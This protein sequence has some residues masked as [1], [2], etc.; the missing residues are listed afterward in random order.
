MESILV[1]VAKYSW[2]VAVMVVMFLIIMWLLYK[3]NNNNIENLKTELMAS[4][5]NVKID[6]ID[7]ANKIKAG[8]DKDVV[9]LKTDQDHL[10]KQLDEVKFNIHKINNTI[11]NVEHN[12]R[13]IER[14]MD[15]VHNT[16]KFMAVQMGG[17]LRVA[18]KESIDNMEE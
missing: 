1:E 8:V 7:N 2:I 5:N 17:D 3:I 10:S 6:M 4:V 14:T 18:I 9:I 12:I 13:S 15:K 16:L 11:T